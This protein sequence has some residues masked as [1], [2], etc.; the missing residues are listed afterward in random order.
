MTVLRQRAKRAVEAFVVRSGGAAL[1]RRRRAGEL[2]VLAYHNVVPDGAFIAGDRSLHLPQAAFRAQLDALRRTHDVVPLA[3]ALMDIAPRRG[4]PLAAITFD[5][6]YRGAVTAGVDELRSRGLPATIFVTPAFLDGHAFWWDLLAHPEHGLDDALRLRAL[7]DLRGRNDEILADDARP[8]ADVAEHARCASVAE[9]EA[10][11]DY[12]GLTLGSHTWSHPNL[13]R[14]EGDELAFELAEPRRWLARYDERALPVISYPYGSA[15]DAV[16]A[17]ARAAG[18]AAGLMIDGGWTPPA[19]RNAFAI[20][21]LNI[22]A[23]VSEHGFV[24]RAAGL[25]QD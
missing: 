19:P 1:G 21:R 25:V 2:L 10:A 24:L 12:P 4:R 7:G 8:R 22:P 23:G 5:D 11:L 15:S 13:A 9:L 14:I 6:A 17:A 20:P 3:D 16:W 18:Y